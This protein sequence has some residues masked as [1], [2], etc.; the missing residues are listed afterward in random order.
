MT[1]IKIPENDLIVHNQIFKTDNHPI[2][3][4]IYPSNAKLYIHS[5]VLKKLID[6]S[7]IAKNNWNVE[8]CI[9][10][11]YR[12]LRYQKILIEKNP[13]KNSNYVSDEKISF[14][15][16]GTA[17]D[18]AFIKNGKLLDY[19]PV[20]FDEKSH[21]DYADLPKDQIDNRE[22]LKKIMIEN[23][24]EPYQYEWWHYNFVGWENYP[25]LDVD[26]DELI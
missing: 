11:A 24:F 7:I 5:T 16:R 1:L 22:N 14:H 2:Y 15:S 17:I 26:F 8:T 13:I 9:F 25:I 23:G 6:I 12:P 4:K 21:H 3:G 10:D 18:I 19:P 20:S